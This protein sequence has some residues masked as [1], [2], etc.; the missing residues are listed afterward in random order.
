MTDILVSRVLAL[1][2]ATAANTASQV[3]VNGQQSRAAAE[4]GHDDVSL[5]NCAWAKLIICQS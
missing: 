5:C 1:E 2:I 4:A 3:V